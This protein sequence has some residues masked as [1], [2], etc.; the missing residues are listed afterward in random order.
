[1]LYQAHINP[2][3][4]YN[5]FIKKDIEKPRCLQVS[6]SHGVSDK[7]KRVCVCLSV[8]LSVYMCI[9]VYEYK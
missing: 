8:C 9:C 1:M 3:N 7:I 6:Q 5:H 2:V 4:Y